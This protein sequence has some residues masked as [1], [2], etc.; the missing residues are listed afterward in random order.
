MPINMYED[1]NVLEKNNKNFDKNT[2]KESIDILEKISRKIKLIFGGLIYG[3][4]IDSN[5]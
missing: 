5:N 3:K 1:D 4:T 2:E